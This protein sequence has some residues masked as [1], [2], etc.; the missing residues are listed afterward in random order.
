[1]KLSKCLF[2]AFAGLGLFA[3]S[4]EEVNEGAI[5]GDANVAVGVNLSALRG[6]ST[7]SVGVSDETEGASEGTAPVTLNSVTL[8]LESLTGGTDEYTFTKE[9]LTGNP[10]ALNHVF[11]GVRNPNKIYV[12]INGGSAEELHLADIYNVGLAAPLYAETTNFGT[13]TEQN[14]VLTYNVTL[15]PKHEIALLEFKGIKHE[16]HSGEKC[17]FKNLT[18][19]GMFLNSVILHE[20]TAGEG[21]YNS[22][23]EAQSDA[24]APT[25][26]TINADF[27]KTQE[28]QL[29]VFPAEAK[30]CYAYNIFPEIGQDNLP[31]LTLCFKD[32]T[33]SES[34]NIAG[35]TPGNPLYVSVAKYKM[36]SLLEDN[37]KVSEE[38]QKK[39]AV[40]ADGYL[41]AFQPGYVYRFSDLIVPDKAFGPT[42]DGGEDAQVIAN[43]EILPWNVVD[44]TV[45]WN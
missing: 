33:L 28:G 18:F 17:L 19:D 1:M 41:Y 32:A 5:K 16:G 20:V 6:E 35:W 10:T 15:S 2:L 40:N 13:A 44:G 3:C 42:P 21:N 43:V 11:S 14:G 36:K 31:K 29:P 7:R 37:G 39:Y 27:L 23:L 45:E 9:E 8:T 34:Q 12:S 38:N 30:K 26:S 25:W 24:A 4:N 22:F